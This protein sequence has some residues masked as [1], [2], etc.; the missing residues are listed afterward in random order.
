MT[1]T[2][3]TVPRVLVFLLQWGSRP[4]VDIIRV[5]VEIGRTRL[6]VVVEV[7]VVVELR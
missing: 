5:A 6:I 1:N 2:V 7:A 3:V 4:R